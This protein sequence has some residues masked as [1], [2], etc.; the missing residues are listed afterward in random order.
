MT[1]AI[2]R[3]PA[4]RVPRTAFLLIALFRAG[5]NRRYGPADA[6]APVSPMAV[7]FLLLG[8]M[9][10]LR[11]MNFFPVGILLLVMKPFRGPVLAAPA[12]G[13]CIR[14]RGKHETRKQ[15]QERSQRRNRPTEFHFCPPSRTVNVKLQWLSPRGADGNC[16]PPSAPVGQ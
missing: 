15:K 1:P 10:R 4:Q 14:R 11:M 16:Q 9:C 3:K 13:P 7:R 6:N 2:Q 8:V 5:C 12:N